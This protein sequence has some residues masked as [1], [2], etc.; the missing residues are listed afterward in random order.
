[1]RCMAYDMDKV[2]VTGLILVI[3]CYII[4][5]GRT[6]NSTITYGKTTLQ[7]SKYCHH[8]N[9]PWTDWANNLYLWNVVAAEAVEFFGLPG[10][11]YI[12][13]ISEHKLTWSFRDP[14]DALLFKLKFSE[15]AC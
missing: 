15:V 14:K 1:M 11:R 12:T 6:N 3:T 10:D 4:L 8:C 9:L 2:F 5:P 13:D 7:E